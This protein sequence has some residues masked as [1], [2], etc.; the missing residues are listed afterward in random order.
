MNAIQKTTFAVSALAITLLGAA[1]VT[2]PL[3]FA[4]PVPR[5]AQVGCPTPSLQLAL[6]GHVKCHAAGRDAGLVALNRR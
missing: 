5:V 6:A 3:A 4:R 1:L 2:A